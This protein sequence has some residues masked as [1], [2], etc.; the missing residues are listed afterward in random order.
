M[1]TTLVRFHPNPFKPR[2]TVTFSLERNEWTSVSI[3]DLTGKRVAVL[4]DGIHRAG[5][6]TLTW[7]GLD[8]EDRV[9]I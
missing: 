1:T 3:Y 9:A 4:A 5:T 7:H 2:T 8:A 6:H